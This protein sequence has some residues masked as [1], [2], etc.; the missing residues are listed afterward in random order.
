MLSR[1]C[2]SGICIIGAVSASLS[3][4]YSEETQLDRGNADK[5]AIPAVSTK[6]AVNVETIIREL[7]EN[8][9]ISFFY[10]SRLLENIRIKDPARPL[11]IK[12][13]DENLH[14][15]LQ[16]YGLEM[17]RISRNT[18]AIT[19]VAPAPVPKPVTKPANVLTD[20]IVVT[21]ARSAGSSGIGS[22]HL[23]EIEYEELSFSDAIT[24]DEIIFDLPQTI[25]DVTPANSA[26]RGALAGI[27]LADMR[28][29]SP[30]RTLVLVNGRR[31][32]P[33]AGGNFSTMLGVDLNRLAQPFIE[34]I[35]LDQLP[36][37]AR[38]G[39]SAI[40]GT[41]NFV[42]RSKFTGV[43]TGARY[44]IAEAGD[45][46][47][48]SLYT[49]AGH[50]FSSDE[51][52]ITVGVS[53][54]SQDGLLG[55]DR[56]ATREMFGFGLNGRRVF[57]PQAGAEFLPG[58]GGEPI[59]QA[60]RVVGAILDNG[61]VAAF[62]SNQTF[63]PN[64]D[65]TVSAFEFTPDQLFNTLA[66]ASIK[67]D[68]ES[69]LGYL[70]FSF[71]I[72]ETIQLTVAAN[73]GGA[74]SNYQFAPA[75]G[76]RFEGSSLLTGDAIAIPL[77]NATLPQSLIDLTVSEVGPSAQS[78][79]FER[80]F[81]EWGARGNEVNRNYFDILTGLK[82]GG[83][84][85][86]IL[87]LEHRYGR[88]SVDW[89]E[90][91]VIDRNKL[92]TAI[93]PVAC[94]ASPGCQPVNLFLPDN[95]TPAAIE[96][97][98]ASPLG[99]K[100]TLTENEISATAGTV[101]EDIIGGNPL[102]LRAGVSY[103]RAE[104]T[105]EAPQQNNSPRIGAVGFA[106]SAKGAVNKTDVFAGATL[107]L[108]SPTS[109]IG[110]LNVSIDGRMTFSSSSDTVINFE[111][112][113]K[114]R[115]FEFLEFFS[116]HQIGERSPNVAELFSVSPS[117]T[118]QFIDPCAVPTEQRSQTVTDNCSSGARLSVGPGFTQTNPL[119]LLK[120]T[121][122][123]K[124]E[125]ERIRSNAVGATMD[126]SEII[127][128]FSGRLD[129]SATWI[130]HRFENSINSF[131]NTIRDCFE[132]VGFSHPFC[133][134]NPVTGEP[135]LIRDTDTD[136][137]VAVDAVR[138][139]FPAASRRGLDLELRYAGRPF[140]IDLI[141]RA[142]VTIAH[143]YTD[144]FRTL[145]RDG[146]YTRSDGG[147]SVPRHESY[148]TAGIENGRIG[149][150]MRITRRG[151]AANFD[152]PEAKIP[153]FTYIDTVLR[154]NLSERAHIQFG[155]ENLFDREPPI[156]AFVPSHNTFPNFYDVVGRRYSVSTRIR[157]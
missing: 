88:T 137:I 99:T 90:T 102:D 10:D 14:D 24:P 120:G 83:K 77:D 128:N 133:G 31:S 98:T 52:N 112:N 144:R 139:N 76:G 4:C 104:L 55:R 68:T 78:L 130:Q 64:S 17:R 46:Q 156:V 141:D 57:Q 61:S 105:T 117:T 148:L 118:V 5:S 18:Y 119:S 103:R 51:G 145:N 50:N 9:G 127:P 34:R 110:S 101:I 15:F 29:F 106:T 21:G 28:G 44:S 132:S 41:V 151:R 150:A 84:N 125:A 124:L 19:A 85:L 23:F 62:P 154:G 129:V 6:H 25:A 108:L 134:I 149:V 113:T 143:T 92:L 91:G 71:D 146:T 72:S 48:Y 135:F 63:V 136:Q 74:Y 42:L 73:G 2:K 95:I 80:R 35:E 122:N 96:F 79:I 13:L 66:P 75:A 147:V 116:H 97:V 30:Q 152:I 37:G 32:T 58:F 100:F 87:S 45:A 20:M 126:L 38:N 89:K 131:S 82:F 7:S 43:E 109:R 40:G 123:P 86:S 67:P 8:L 111:A 60:G 54:L 53:Y 153:S 16:G 65:G 33:T 11:E 3:V 142:W 49:L 140:D 81:T 157:F 114:W 27:S 47:R 59:T 70:D 69:I 107:G 36:A 138:T 12:A 22:A 1:L 94:T 155:I 39:E 93:N 115:P 121:G 26:F 56:E